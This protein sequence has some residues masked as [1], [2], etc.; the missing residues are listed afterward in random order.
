MPMSPG[1]DGALLDL[2]SH[3]RRGPAADRLSPAQLELIRR[4]IS[5]TPEVMVKVSG[6]GRSIQA[7]QAHFAY[8]DRHGKLE[9]ETDDG[10]RMTGKGADRELVEDWDLDLE[11]ANVTPHQNDGGRRPTK[12]VHNIVFSMPAGTPPARLLAA[13]QTFAREEFALKHRYAMVLH[14]D[15]DHPHVH[16]VVKAMSEQ[17]ARLNIRKADLRA[18]RD[19]FARQLRDQ[20]V[21]A[22]A[23]RRAVRGAVDIPKRS[24]IFQA[25]RRRQSTQLRG[26]VEAIKAELQQGGL[27]AEPVKAK[28]AA[29]RAGVI[30]GW[31]VVAAVLSA[32]GQPDLAAGV[33]KFIDRMP[34]PLTDKERIAASIQSLD[35][36]PERLG[37]VR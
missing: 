26:R 31:A 3:A 2:A 25:M 29:S 27:T 32:Q 9:I 13:V 20:G 22:N 30:R 19:Q 24:D 17:G 21:P 11:P 8:I 35:R 37:P 28:I 23:T 33:V 12:L 1:A 4:T 36:R 15:Q 14:T 6:G 5:R 16:M 18:W 7:V 10:Q 34:E